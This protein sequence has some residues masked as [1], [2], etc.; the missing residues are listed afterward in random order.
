VIYID[1]DN[2]ITLE[3]SDALEEELSF[4]YTTNTG[5]LN[6]TIEK[7][8]ANK[9]KITIALRNDT[10]H[11]ELDSNFIRF[12]WY[13]PVVCTMSYRNKDYTIVVDSSVSFKIKPIDKDEFNT[14]V[15]LEDIGK[16][17][18]NNEVEITLREKDYNKWHSFSELKAFL[19]YKEDEKFIDVA[20]STPSNYPDLSLDICKA[21]FINENVDK[22]YHTFRQFVPINSK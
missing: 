13:D 2:S 12:R 18:N 4:D 9:E 6:L 10:F 20:F 17:L 15:N 3:L 19:M 1:N 16:Q 8:K 21:V 7:F 22:V 14:L 11:I 5:L